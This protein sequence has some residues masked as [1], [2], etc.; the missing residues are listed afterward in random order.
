MKAD[1][2]LVAL[3]HL[4]EHDAL[5]MC[6]RTDLPV[7]FRDPGCERGRLAIRAVGRLVTAALIIANEFE[8]ETKI[9]PDVVLV[10][11]QAVKKLRRIL[12]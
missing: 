1:E 9:N 2:I 7:R 4:Y 8:F 5:E 11:W 12:L 6:S 10:P 3:K